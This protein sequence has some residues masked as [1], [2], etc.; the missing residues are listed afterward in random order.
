MTATSE[1]MQKIKHL[2]VKTYIYDLKDCQKLKTQQ[3]ETTKEFLI[4][5]GFCFGCLLRRH[6]SKNCKRRMTCKRCQNKR[7]TILHLYQVKPAEPV[8]QKKTSINSG[9]VTLKAGGVT[10]ASKDC[11]LSI[12][13][14]KVKTTKGSKYVL[15]YAFLDP[16]SSGMFCTER[17]RRQFNARGRKTE[18]LLRT[19]RQL[20]TV[21][22][23]E[24][25]GLEVGK[26][27]PFGT[28]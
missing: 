28:P 20:K 4:T 27:T 16:G 25:S 26:G 7:P 6:M 3:R 10:R 8:K 15:T 9:H 5:K 11:A 19:M 13:P 24:L 12:M 21:P 22:S 2:N 14:V 17:L 23:Y 18:I 1:P